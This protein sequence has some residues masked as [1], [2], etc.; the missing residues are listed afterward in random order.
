MSDFSHQ[1][2]PDVVFEFQATPK[3]EEIMVLNVVFWIYSQNQVT[4]YWYLK[5]WIKN[6]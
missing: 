2:C 3:M 4:Y 6:L 1:L 5:N